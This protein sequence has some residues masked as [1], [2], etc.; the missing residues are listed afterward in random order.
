MTQI[1]KLNVIGNCAG[2]H[3]DGLDVVGQIGSK[4]CRECGEIFPQNRLSIPGQYV[5][6]HKPPFARSMK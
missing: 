5:P 2:S 1:H 6:Q 4:H 3:F